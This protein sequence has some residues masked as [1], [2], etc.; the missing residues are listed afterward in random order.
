MRVPS[1]LLR[2]GDYAQVLSEHEIRASLDADGSLQGVSFM[3]EM[4]PFCGTV[5]RVCK[6]VDKIIDMVQH[7]GLRRM[8]STV[9]LDGLRCNGG[10]HGGCQTGCQFLWKEAWL[11]RVPAP[12]RQLAAPDCDL[13][14][15]PPT[16]Q[17]STANTTYR[18]QATELFEAS[19]SLHK[20]DVR[21]FVAP[22]WYGNVGGR[23]FLRGTSVEAFNAVQRWRG[24]CEYPY[25]PGSTLEKTPS[26]ALGLQPGEWVRVKQ[27]DEILQTLDKRNRNRG[28][29]FDREML[30]FCGGRF[31][32][33]RRVE[34]LIE[35]GSGKLIEPKTACIILE[36]VSARGEFYRFNPQN[37][38]ILWRE[39]WLER[40]AAP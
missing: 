31:K 35:E 29:W 28:L 16:P 2:A 13:A 37:D 26:V 17:A 40:T 9:T 38:Y 4:V 20:W 14:P 7:T 34:R 30:I 8:T 12:L 33:L 21:Q 25:W 10:A 39:I 18:C 5:H 22:L 3:P 11:R 24:A 36:G 32:V 23:E 1:R 19:S 15:A 27:K 6:R